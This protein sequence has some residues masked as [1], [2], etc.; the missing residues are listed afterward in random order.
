M[1]RPINDKNSILIPCSECGKDFRILRLRYNERKKRN[2]DATMYCSDE[3]LGKG[4]SKIQTKLKT[5]LAW[6]KG[7][8]LVTQC[9]TCGKDVELIK[10]HLKDRNFCCNACCIEYMA[11]RNREKPCPDAYEKWLAFVDKT[12]GQGPNGDCWIW[13]GSFREF[14]GLREPYGQFCWPRVRLMGAHVASYSLDTGDMETKGYEICHH[15]DNPPCVNPAHLFKGTREDNQKD[16]NSKLRR[17]LGA[18]APKAKLTETQV[19]EIRQLREKGMTC[20]ELG[21][22]YGVH[23]STIARAG[24]GKTFYHLYGDS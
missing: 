13:T 8:R 2:P 3:C 10:F 18:K 24:G 20:R 22:V 7:S 16:C 19:L 9:F 23:E 4:K 12:P 11:Q 21:V 6:S 5:E 15:C 1:P 17:P 14:K